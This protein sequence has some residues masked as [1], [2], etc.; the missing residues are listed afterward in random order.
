MSKM[1]CFLKHIYIDNTIFALE[2]SS[3]WKT[4][5]L[6]ASLNGSLIWDKWLVDVSLSDKYN[7]IICVIL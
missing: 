2:L 7:I 1:L 3:Q 6:N 5:E 4:A